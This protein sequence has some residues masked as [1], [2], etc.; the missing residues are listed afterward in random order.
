[1]IK[2]SEFRL[3]VNQLMQ[4]E[5]ESLRKIFLPYKRRPLLRNDIVIDL[6]YKYNKANVLGYYTNTQEN[7]RQWKFT[8]KIFITKLAKDNY[9]HY[10][11]WGF[12]QMAI[13]DLKSTIRHELVH[14]YVFEEFDLFGDIDHCNGD[15][16]PIFLS[17]LYWCGEEFVYPYTDKFKDTELFKQISQ[18]KK[19]DNVCTYLIHYMFE[20]EQTVRNINQKI[21]KSETDYKNLKVTFN[22]YGAGMI[23]SSYVSIDVKTKKDNKLITQKA[24]EMTLGIGFLV[25]PKDLIENYERKFDNGSIGLIH[26]E[27]AAYSI[28]NEFKQKTVIRE[29][30]NFS[31]IDSAKQVHS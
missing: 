17:C 26:S 9:Q 11:K 13:D 30:D 22:Q 27:M 31:E 25:T 2:K 16:S 15:Y 3:L 20:L 8:H 6:D 5:L 12:K 24:T 1:M 29:S 21:N 23:K 18:C 7:E 10:A 28:D 14:A 4:K 19:F